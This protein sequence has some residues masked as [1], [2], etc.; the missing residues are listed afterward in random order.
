[1]PCPVPTMEDAIRICRG[2]RVLG[3]LFVGLA[4]T[5]SGAGAAEARLD[6]FDLN[7]YGLSYHPDR[8]AARSRNVDNETNPGLGIHFEWPENIRG[9]YFAEAGAYLD[10]GEN[11]AKFAALG[12]QFR[13][14]RRWKLGGALAAIYSRTYNNGTAFVA[15]IPLVTWDLGRFK[16]NAVYF[17]K[18]GQHNQVDVLG[19]YVSLPLGGLAR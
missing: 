19:F 8:E 13:A 17:P 1:M 16:L 10:S 3:C 9:N 14:G 5:G 2:C 12:Y 6:A 7:I 18:F 11:W 4:L 15:M